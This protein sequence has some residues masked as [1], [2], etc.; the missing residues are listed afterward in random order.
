MQ[1]A[2][3]VEMMVDGR[4]VAAEP[5]ESLAVALAASG[6]MVLRRSP[7]QDAPRGVFCMMGVC[8]ECAVLV[9]GQRTTACTERVR[10]GMVVGTDAALAPEEGAR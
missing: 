9:D 2:P 3:A 6:I 7:G 4:P 1:R 5:G 8:Q 10:A